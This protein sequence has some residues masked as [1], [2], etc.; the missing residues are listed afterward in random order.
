MTKVYGQLV[1]AQVNL[2]NTG[3]V[4]IVPAF[5]KD[6]TDQVICRDYVTLAGNVIGD[7]VSLGFFKPTAFIDLFNCFLLKDALGAGVTCNIGD[8]SNV[9]GLA[10]AIALSAAG[11]VGI[12]PGFNSPGIIGPLWQRLS[13]PTQPVGDLELLLTFAGANPGA[14]GL[15]WQFSGWNT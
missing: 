10:A 2:L 5:L 14:G 1:G 11:W 8:V 9:S 6:W 12:K 3:G 15:G 7:Q 13:Y 4:G